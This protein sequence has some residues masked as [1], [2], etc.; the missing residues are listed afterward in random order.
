MF[1]DAD[2]FGDLSITKVGEFYLLI[3]EYITLL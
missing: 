1:A 3:V 2:Q